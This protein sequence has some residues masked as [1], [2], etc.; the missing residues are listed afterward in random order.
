[1]EITKIFLTKHYEIND[2]EKVPIIKRK[3]LG[4]EG[5]QCIHTLTVTEKEATNH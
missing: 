3:W 5:L 1:M 4:R 2:T